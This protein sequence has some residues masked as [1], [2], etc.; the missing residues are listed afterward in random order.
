MCLTSIQQ[1]AVDCVA[2]P[3]M[4]ISVLERGLCAAL[5]KFAG[6]HNKENGNVR[7]LENDCAQCREPSEAP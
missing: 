2:G 4:N 1:K 7:A 5:P 3:I 6:P